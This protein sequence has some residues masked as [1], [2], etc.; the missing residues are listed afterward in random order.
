MQNF[1]FKPNFTMND[2][3][4]KNI[5][6]PNFN[7]NYNFNIGQMK[8]M[9]Q[10]KIDLCKNSVSIIDKLQNIYPNNSV[11]ANEI[12]NIYNMSLN[13]LRESSK[14][15]KLEDITKKAQFYFNLYN[16]INKKKC[17]HIENNVYKC[18]FLTT[19]LPNQSN[20]KKIQI[21]INNN[22]FHGAI[23]NNGFYSFQNR[24]G[25]VNSNY[26]N[27]SFSQNSS[28]SSITIDDD[29]KLNKG[30]K[31]K[32]MVNKDNENGLIGKKR[33]LDDKAINGESNN[34]KKKVENNN[35]N[36]KN[37]KSKKG[38]SPMLEINKNQLKSVQKLKKNDRKNNRDKKHR[39]KNDYNRMNNRKIQEET[40]AKFSWEKVS[41]KEEE[42][43]FMNFEKDLKDYLR[44]TISAN[45]QNEFFSNV[46][47]ESL[48]IVKNLF[49][50][51]SNLQ[52]N[53]LY[54]IYRNDKFELSL[55]IEPG[56]K[57][58]K[59]LTNFNI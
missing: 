23:I 22:L 56:G 47:P 51:N 54:P 14:N 48:D 16:I 25:F 37:Q 20:N 27:N 42:E 31:S 49:Q 5:L 35:N 40:E 11:T 29:D 58:R 26:N 21:N 18:S 24:N 3:R 46:I 38:E 39:N 57:I 9:D 10:N 43:K 28:K 33:N 8:Q 36:N 32:K 45:R 55:I 17:Q 53:K 7:Y 41:E 2:I 34:K 50:K 6:M 12:Y 4:N 30:T 15:N 19:N 13:N 1:G 44:R 59:Q 52:V